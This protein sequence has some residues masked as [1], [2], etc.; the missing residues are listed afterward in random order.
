MVETL[1][2]LSAVLT[3]PICSYSVRFAFYMMAARVSNGFL[4]TVYIVNKFLC[5]MRN[6]IGTVV[7]HIMRTTKLNGI[8]AMRS[9]NKCFAVL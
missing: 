1:G 7:L 5:L 6:L 8:C 9:I 2:L 3:A 4:Y